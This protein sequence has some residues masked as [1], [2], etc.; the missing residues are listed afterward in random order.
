MQRYHDTTTDPLPIHSP[1]HDTERANLARQTAEFL[2]RGG[3]VQQIGFCMSNTP[4]TFTINPERSPVYAHLFVPVASEAA[5]K[6]QVLPEPATELAQTDE[7]K[8]AAL[9]MADAALGNSPKWI[10]KKHHMTEKRV[11][12][13]ARDYHITFHVQR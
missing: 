4:A 9:I 7:Q 1:Q 5:P 6:G 13:I 8:L 12:Q 10:A 11:R 2:A 3:N